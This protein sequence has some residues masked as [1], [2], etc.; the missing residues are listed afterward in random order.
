MAEQPTE[1]LIKIRLR[2]ME[3]ASVPLRKAQESL[4]RLKASM[5]KIDKDFGRK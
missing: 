4:D 2:L 3:E 5:A 1:K